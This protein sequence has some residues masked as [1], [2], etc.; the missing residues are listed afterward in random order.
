MEFDFNAH[1]FSDQF[2]DFD[3]KACALAMLVDEAERGALRL[4]GDVQRAAVHDL[5]DRVGLGRSYRCCMSCHECSGPGNEGFKD[6]HHGFLP[7]VDDG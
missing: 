5:L 4:H 2:H 7:L 6:V 1:V 3:G